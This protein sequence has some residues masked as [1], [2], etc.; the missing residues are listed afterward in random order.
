MLF[1]RDDIPF[2]LLS[3]ENKP[4]EGFYV[5][6]NLRRT[7]WLLCCSYNPSRSNID[8]H[9]EHLNRN[10]ALYSSRY[11]NFMV[12][13]DFN[14]EANNSAMSIFC[15]TYNLKN[16]IK[17]LTCCKNPSKPSCIDHMLKL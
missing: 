6:I 1:V 2:K 9:L 5:E 11:E 3:L 17:E 10:L 7:K 15:D 4:M 16:L 14:V 13:G 12:I 8:F